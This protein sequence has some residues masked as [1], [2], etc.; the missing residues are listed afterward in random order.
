[1]LDHADEEKRI[2]SPQRHREHTEEI[3]SASLR[4]SSYGRKSSLLR[5]RPVS[6]VK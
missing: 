5:A 1:M 4:E 6:V 3:F 2:D